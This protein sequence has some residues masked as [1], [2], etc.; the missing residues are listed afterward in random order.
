MSAELAPPR[1]RALPPSASTHS[2][3]PRPVSASA[4][5]AALQTPL[6]DADES[7]FSV[8][9]L[10]DSGPYRPQP[11]GVQGSHVAR[12]ASTVTSP[13]LNWLA[14]LVAAYVDPDVLI[15]AA[16]SRRDTR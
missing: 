14:T 2:L 12:T 13:P 3:R 1:A 5:P 10:G 11:A 16:R 4:Q 9:A 8:L 15:G 7:T 6:S